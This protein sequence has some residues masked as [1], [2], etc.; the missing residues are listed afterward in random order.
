MHT[1]RCPVTPSDLVAHLP[2]V[3]I[4]RRLAVGLA[5]LA[6]VTVVVPA[7]AAPAKGPLGNFKH[8]VVIYEENHSFD[9]LY[10]L[11]GDVN[12]QHVVGLGDADDAHTTQV[13]QGGDPYHCLLQTDISLQT[14]VQTYPVMSATNVL[15]AGAVGEQTESCTQ[16]VTLGDGTTKHISSA[17]ENEPYNIDEAI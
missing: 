10:G 8:I 4:G 15:P 9:N 13:D 5:A 7:A 14:S 3:A 11:W 2:R 1:W 16:D 12:G 17:F 6:L